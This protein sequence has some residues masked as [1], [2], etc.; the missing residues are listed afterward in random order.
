MT[1]WQPIETAPK[2][3]SLILGLEKDSDFDRPI[4]W[5]VFWNQE[6]RK[7]EEFYD[8]F[9]DPDPKHWIPIPDLPEEKNEKS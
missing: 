1:E 8:P 2:D 4:L 7:W 6:R 5:V 9:Y 3:G